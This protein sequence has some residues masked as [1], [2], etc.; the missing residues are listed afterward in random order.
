[1]V[2]VLACGGRSFEDYALLAITMESIRETR[3]ISSLIAGGARGAD[4]LAEEWAR[5][6]GI[7]CSVLRAD[8]IGRGR[9]AGPIRNQRMLD[10]GKPDLVVAFP[11]GR[12]TADMM[13]KARAAG[14]EVIEVGAIDSRLET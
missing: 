6:R 1:M 14:V 11:G 2:R 10:E 13:S 8:W 4:T 7:E 5:A 3:G 12:G 9:A